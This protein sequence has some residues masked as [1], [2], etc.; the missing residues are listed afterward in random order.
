MAHLVQPLLGA[1][2]QP[3]HHH[4]A[5]CDWS[6]VG[7]NTAGTRW[8]AATT[9]TQCLAVLARAGGF[10]IRTEA[11]AD[12]RLHLCSLHLQFLS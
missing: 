6:A 2:S 4:G 12:I 9:S 11:V 5:R 8:S 3:A 1:L 10:A 7:V